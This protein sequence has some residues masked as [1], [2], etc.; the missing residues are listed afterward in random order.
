V[1][2][3]AEAL[4][5]RIAFDLD[6]TLGVPVIVGATMVGWQ[7]RP[8]C[9][10]LL[11]RLRNRFVLCLWTV[12]RRAYVDKAL[13]FGLGDWF[14]ETYTWDERPAPWKDVRQIRAD[15]LIDDSPHHREAA[16]AVGL[17]SA[18]IVVPQYGSPEDA[19]D[20]L[21]W[22]RLIEST[23]RSAGERHSHPSSGDF[24]L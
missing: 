10:D 19:A 23:V 1:S 7:V 21:A 15:F 16:R 22:V 24:I 20:S 6:E 5:R 2:E 11:A 8:G 17:E 13:S 4:V 18:Y 3:S 9:L 12:S 14:A